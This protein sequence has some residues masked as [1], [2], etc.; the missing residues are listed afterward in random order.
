M[1]ERQ[2]ADGA[3]QRTTLT[4]RQAEQAAG[5]DFYI[6][7]DELAGWQAGWLRAERAACDQFSLSLKWSGV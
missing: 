2:R 3:E 1:A 4:A 7:S 5:S 6:D